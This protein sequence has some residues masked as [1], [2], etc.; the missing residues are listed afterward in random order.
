DMIKK[1]G[2]QVS[3]TVLSAE[4]MAKCFFTSHAPENANPR[5]VAI[6]NVDN[7]HTDFIVGHAGKSLY[8]RSIPVGNKNFALES[9]A[10]RD[11][12]LDEL[13]KSIE[14]YQ[15]ENVGS[16]PQSIFFTGMMDAAGDLKEKML[17]F[18]SIVS[19]VVTEAWFIGLGSQDSTITR[20]K[21]GAAVLSIITP[22]CVYGELELDLIPE[23]VKI[24]KAVKDHTRLMTK[25]A[26]FSLI[27]IFLFCTGLLTNMIFKNL[28]LEKLSTSYTSHLSE[29]DKLKMTSTKTGTVELFLNKKGEVLRILTELFN[30]LP[31]EVYLNSLGYRD[32]RTLSFAG[33]TDNMSRVFSLVTDLENNKYFS[34]VKVDSTR[35]RRVDDKEVADFGLTITV[36][37]GI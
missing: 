14:S 36:E 22:P 24:R 32:D 4:S 3:R 28:Y 18:T 6:V 30:A 11:K 34:N 23:D 16:L 8:I 19:N 9:E 2:F 17:T 29:A 13:K 26:A 20:E 21:P 31:P 1:A 25:V 33:T 27:S 37:D 35:T 5:P 12:F 15:S 10:A 7:V